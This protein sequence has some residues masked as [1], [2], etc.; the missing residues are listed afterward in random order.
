MEIP[1]E[2]QARYFMEKALLKPKRVRVKDLEKEKIYFVIPPLNSRFIGKVSDEE[3]KINRMWEYKWGDYAKVNDSVKLMDS[4]AFYEIPSNIP[5][6]SP[7][8]FT[9]Y[10]PHEEERLRLIP[11]MNLGEAV[12][13]SKQINYTTN[14]NTNTNNSQA[15]T[16]SFRNKK[17]RKRRRTRKNR[18]YQRR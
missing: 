4:M 8:G 17:E 2:E 16:A 18:R 9:T 3:G 12:I 10:D 7:P 5:K 6:F 14:S 11:K 15:R 1:T 13:K